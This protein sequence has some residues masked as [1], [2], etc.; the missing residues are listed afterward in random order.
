VGGGGGHKGLLERDA[1]VDRLQVWAEA[2]G[3]RRGET[4]LIEGEAGIG[5]TVL[6]ER[7]AAAAREGGARV[8]TA[9]G[10]ELEQE[11]PYG[12][13]R[14][15]L[16]REL[17]SLEDT[18]RE[19]LLSGAASLAAAVFWPVQPE[20]ATPQPPPNPLALQHGLYWL[21]ANLAEE[22]PL[23]L[24]IDDLHWIDAATLRFLVYLARRLEAMP[25]A[26][27]AAVRLGEPAGEHTRLIDALRFTDGVESMELCPLGPSSVASLVSQRL[28]RNPAPDFAAACHEL[29]GGNPFLLDELLEQ[30]TI[31]EAERASANVARLR[32]VAPASVSRAALLRVAR[33]SDRAVAFAQAIAVLGG[34][35][36]RGHAAAL[37]GI[38]NSDA[39]QLADALV[40]ARILADG[41][42]QFRHPLVRAAIYADLPEGRRAQDHA[43]AAR[44]LADSG[45]P[46][47][48]VAG[49]LLL[50]DP[51]GEEWA[52]DALVEAAEL[53][54]AR[55]GPD[56]AATFLSRA[57]AEP[58]QPSQR[59]AL[60]HMLGSARFF[61]GDP[62]GALDCL[63]QALELTDRIDQRAP[64]VLQVGSMLS[65]L[66]RSQE[67]V[68]ALQDMIARVDGDDDMRSL[69]DGALIGLAE[70]DVTTAGLVREHA[71][72][73]RLAGATHQER[74]MLATLAFDRAKHGDSAP[75]AVAMATRALGDGQLFSEQP[76]DVPH[77]SFAVLSLVIADEFDA[78]DAAIEHLM[79]SARM[80]GSRFRFG[81]ASSL[82]S[83]LCVRTGA[84]ED[85]V[86]AARDALSAALEAGWPPP[87]LISAA[88]LIEALLERGD[89]R[90]AAAELAAVTIDEE[91]L[92]G[93]TMYPLFLLQARGRLGIAL[94]DVREGLDDLL[95][96][97]RRCETWGI[98]NPALFAWRSEAALALAQVGDRGEAKRLAG[99]DVEL[100]RRFGAPRAIA[101]ALRAQALAEQ[102]PRSV[103]LLEEAASV[104]ADSPAVL[105]RAHVLV[106][107]GAALR[108]AN[109]RREARGHLL[110]GLELATRCDAGP[111]IER[112]RDELRATGARPRRVQRT[113]V[114]ALTP[115]ERRVCLL[116]AEGLS[117]PEIAQSLFVTRATVES[118]LHS[119]YGKLEIASRNELARVLDA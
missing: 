54:L 72:G 33:L 81:Q 40:D 20:R 27:V 112:A 61:A 1:E 114:D 19:R 116:A 91:V 93:T 77:F 15:L 104:L 43:H 10:G 100:A 71:D 74:L 11:F 8:L 85:A 42:L 4:L 26:V 52:V 50:S 28:G 119:A 102:S 56:A 110:E 118:H 32:A 96:L 6:L 87:V 111:L 9:R 106:D 31:S 48:R 14:Q 18:R 39:R 46:P 57:L 69:L 103:E 22:H 66:G 34:G 44:V 7:A 97:G 38:D 75:A 16:E 109:R 99:E 49:H 24:V 78:A 37:A 108:R 53:A 41:S 3:E 82:R 68:G 17:A 30:F 98:Y 113:G 2:A 13:I 64:I 94:G 67:A 51:L 101:M 92:S 95:E 60:L 63:G 83:S 90:A 117:N 25:L 59:A 88:V 89:P 105:T 107:L 62:A 35:A 29:V 70:L 115:S 12:G 73:E 5:K 47:D 21:L 36:E 76:T 55:G 58:P 86:A 84:I 80:R 45:A 23:A 79:I 65:A